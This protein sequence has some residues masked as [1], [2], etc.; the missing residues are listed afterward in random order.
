[1]SLPSDSPCGRKDP[2]GIIAISTHRY[3]VIIVYIGI[4][5]IQVAKSAISNKK[6]GSFR[7]FKSP[8]DFG[9]L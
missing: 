5:I 3:V 7:H 4:Y 9:D 8:K 2:L 6:K 1:M